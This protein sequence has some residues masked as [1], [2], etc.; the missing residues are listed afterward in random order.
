[1]KSTL[2]FLFFLV[3]SLNGFAK[4]T[5]TPSSGDT[6]VNVTIPEA[7]FLE[8]DVVTGSNVTRIDCLNGTNLTTLPVAGLKIVIKRVAVQGDI[9]YE[10]YNGEPVKFYAAC[11]QIFVNHSLR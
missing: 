11:S 9:R 1:M 7:K 4:S 3:L 10:V 6:P 5:R 2:F 8:Q